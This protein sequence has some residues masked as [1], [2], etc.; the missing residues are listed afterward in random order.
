LGD[1]E[2]ALLQ[3]AEVVRDGAPREAEAVGDVLGGDAGLLLDEA[4]DARAVGVLQDLVVAEVAV[5]GQQRGEAGELEDAPDAGQ[6]QQRDAGGRGATMKR[7]EDWTTCTTA[8]V[9]RAGGEGGGTGVAAE[10]RRMSTVA[11]TTS[12]LALVVETL[13]GSQTFSTRPMSRRLSL[14]L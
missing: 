3:L 4:V 7:G 1:D 11:C 13:P 12:V 14:G 5:E 10:G 8:A 6:G 2:A 9:A